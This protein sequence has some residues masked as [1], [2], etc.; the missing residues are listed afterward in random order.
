LDAGSTS[1]TVTVKG[2]GLQL[3]QIQDNGHGIQKEDLPIV[4][5]RFTTSKLTSFDDLKTITTFGFR[6]EALASITHVAHVTITTRTPD[7][8]C[9]YKAKYLDG[10]LAP[11]KDGDKAEPKACA[12][13]QGTTITV[14]D[15]FYNMQTRKQAFKNPNEQY[16]HILDVVTKYS[17]H[18]GDSKVAFTCK[19]QGQGMPDLHT[20]AASTT[21][22]NIKIAYGAQVARELI[23]FELTE[24]GSGGGGSSSSSSS[25]SS[26][27]AAAVA[28]PLDGLPISRKED[29]RRLALAGEAEDGLVFS[30]TGLIS[31]ANYSSKKSVCILF[32]NNRLV[33]CHSIKRV[34]ETVYSEVLP[35]HGHPFIYLSLRMPPQV[36][37]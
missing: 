7:A 33:E 32:I 17:V 20:P 4:C 5:E 24:V 18:F 34:I 12:G 21:L 11:L 6:G 25:S 8:P 16:H 26:A 31:N 29:E 36:P 30:M 2:G 22:D 19:K 37:P 1:I 3:L 35:R 13:T 9:A 28:A 10:K 23:R 15:L 14:E 27:T